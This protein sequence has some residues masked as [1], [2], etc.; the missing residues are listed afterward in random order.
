MHRHRPMQ[1]GEALMA[2][3][4]FIEGGLLLSLVY[5][6]PDGMIAEELYPHGS[7]AS[8]R[9]LYRNRIRSR[10]LPIL[11]ALQA[12]VAAPSPHNVQPWKL[13]ILDDHTAHLFV[14]P[15]RLLP[16]TDPPGRQILIGQGCFLEMART[17]GSMAGLRV[18]DTL[19]PE[20]EG[21]DLL[22]G[23]R[24][25]ARIEVTVDQSIREE[26][27]A[28]FIPKR[29]TDRGRFRN[30]LLPLR[31][32]EKLKEEARHF[33]SRLRLFEE[34]GQMARIRNL[35]I[36][37]M[38]IESDTYRTNEES[39]IWF[40]TTDEEIYTRR[41]GISLRGNALSGLRLL[42][43]RHLFFSTEPDSF[44][45][46]FNR[47]AAVH[48]LEEAMNSTSTCLSLTTEGNTQREQILAGKDYLRLQ[49]RA[50]ALGIR[51]QP[52]SQI[53]QEYPE[54]RAPREEFE[55]LAGVS[56]GEKVQ[57]LLR[58]GRGS[59]E[60]HSPRRNLDDLI[61]RNPFSGEGSRSS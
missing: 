13:E 32:K 15:K 6:I 26:P 28:A 58:A 2:R 53:L 36:K 27:L 33:H 52:I 50:A 23:R 8:S 31:V 42:L 59:M 49:L 12:G 20:G 21:E 56:S 18:A 30:Q 39:R 48:L 44:H 47:D 3:K 45:S 24:P 11:Q 55:R 17:G 4:A 51:L 9:E 41:D 37:G 29:I 22:A 61:R 1:A 40:R 54:M 10:P 46:R 43:A 57:M 19:L 35:A 5:L 38:R 14:D 7:F 34:P 60:F 16:F 25:V